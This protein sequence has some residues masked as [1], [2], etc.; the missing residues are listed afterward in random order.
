MYD[1]II[2]GGMVVTGSKLFQADIAIQD[3][4]IAELAPELNESAREEKDARGLFIFPGLID[5][6]VHFNEP[7]RNHWEGLASGSSALAAGGGTLFADMPLN[8]DPP[9]LSSS[10]FA[11]KLEAAKHQSVTDFAFWGGLTPDNLDRLEELAHCGV[12]GFKAFMSDSG[13]DEFR[14]ADDLTLYRGMAKAAQLGLPVAVHAES[15]AITKRLTGDL[16]TLGRVDIEAYLESRP[17][18]AE[19][20]AINRA[21]LY[22]RE[23]GCDLHIVHVSNA[24]GMALISDARMLGAQVSSETCPHYLHFSSDD[25]LQKG[26]IAKCAPPLRSETERYALWQSVLRGEVDMISSDHSPSEPELKDRADFFNVWG[27]IAGV[28]S[29]LNV[30]LSHRQE[31]GLPLEKI[32]QMCSSTPASRFSLPDKGYLEVGFDADLCLVAID[33]AFTL[34][35]NELFYKHKYSPYTGQRFTGRV[36]Q[37]LLRGKTIF[38]EGRLEAGKAELIKPHV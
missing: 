1:L 27:G 4:K 30:L 28:Q 21:L 12:I 18:L 34:T 24:R 33:E 35:A 22:A 3:E 19:L 17:I 6:H 14:A 38:K 20:E 8:S 16:R 2:R 5:T 26:A 11:A 9:L 32:A 25:L 15:E 13:I 31:Q 29:T 23:T 36:K 10:D 7:G 37:T